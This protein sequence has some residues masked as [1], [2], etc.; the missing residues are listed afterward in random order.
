[1][2]RLLGLFALIVFATHASGATCMNATATTINAFS[3][4]ILSL[5]RNEFD[6]RA[7]YKSI[8]TFGN[9]VRDGENYSVA[10]FA[11]CKRGEDPEDCGNRFVEGF[12]TSAV[13]SIRESEKLE[14]L[15]Q[16]NR[17]TQADAPESAKQKKKQR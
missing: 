12:V 5:C 16:D 6:I 17:R 15:C 3:E 11:S 8:Q 4:K 10:C 9:S 2:K 13:S 7:D 1:M 14:R